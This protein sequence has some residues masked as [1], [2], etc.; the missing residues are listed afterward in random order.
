MGKS[1]PVV[2][3]P[4]RLLLPGS[5]PSSPCTLGLVFLK[6]PKPDPVCYSVGPKHARP[7]GS[8]SFLGSDEPSRGH[9]E[10]PDS[11]ARL[12]H[13]ESLR[14]MRARPSGAWRV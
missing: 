8:A 7:E 2:R 3:G 6:A 13:L 4:A 14:S 11:R 10:L 9:R 1:F 5:F 12:P